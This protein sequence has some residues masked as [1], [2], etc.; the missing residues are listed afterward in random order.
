MV[1][2]DWSSFGAATVGALVP[3]RIRDPRALLRTHVSH[4][5]ADGNVATDLPLPGS[6]AAVLLVSIQVRRASGSPRSYEIL[7]IDRVVPTGINFERLLG[8][9]QAARAALYR[10]VL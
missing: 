5:L 9:D 3:P 4:S 10:K 6:N 8:M 2:G 1:K 7:R